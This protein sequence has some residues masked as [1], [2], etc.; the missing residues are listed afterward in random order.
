MNKQQIKDII[1]AKGYDD[2]ITVKECSELFKTSTSHIYRK[3]AEGKIPATSK[4][5]TG[6]RLIMLDDIAESLATEREEIQSCETYS[7][8]IP[9]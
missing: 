6:K 3:I 1:K 9:M 8:D 7:Q 5:L 4:G 2:F